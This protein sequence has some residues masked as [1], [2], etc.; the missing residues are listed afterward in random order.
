M[1]PTVSPGESLLIEVVTRTLKLGHEFTQ[2]TADS[3]EVWLDVTVRSGDRVIG[4]SGGV[5][6][7]RAVDPWSK[8]FNVFML[9]RAGNRIDRRNPQDIFVPLYNNQV[10]PG[11]G[12]V[13]HFGLTLPADLTDPVTIDVALRYRKFDT[14]YM[15]YA[16]PGSGANTLP[17]LTLAT[18]SVTLPLAGTST[19]AAAATPSASPTFPEWQRWYDYAIGLFR[20]GNRGSQKGD[21]RGAE[22]AFATVEQLGRGEG[23]L[24]LARTYLKEGRLD[25]AVAALSRAGQATNPAYPWS[26]AWFSAQV[27]RQNGNFEAAVR[28]MEAVKASA[29]PLAI[30][31]GFDFSRDDRLLVDLGQVRYEWARALRSSDAVRADAV[32]DRAHADVEAALRL[33]PESASA[34]Y[35]LAQIRA[36]LGDGAGAE[37]ALAAHARYKLD[38][39]ARDS[40]ITAARARYPA[41][42]HA[43]EPIVIYDL[44]RSGRLEASIADPIAVKSLTGAGDGE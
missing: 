40:A 31:R 18:D 37:A 26:I 6:A 22:Q 4:R 41:A 3:N 16:Y 23:A 42:N 28:N 43:A 36:E 14:T 15:H 9:D 39:N 35:V 38:D 44:Q 33:D 30:E 32:L 1:L 24:G 13:T 8:F 10:P 27:D 17:V 29:F 7:D 5:D 20:Q 34:W 25:D 21:L 19:Q 11:A 2:G 12:D